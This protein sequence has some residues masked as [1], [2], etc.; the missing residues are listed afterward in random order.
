MKILRSITVNEMISQYL[1]NEFYSDCFNKSIVKQLKDLGLSQDIILNP[2]INDEVQNDFRGRILTGYRGFANKTF[3]FENFPSEVEWTRALINQDEIFRIQYIN[4]E[5]WIELA[6]GTRSP[7]EAS[8]NIRYELKSFNPKIV[9][10]AESLRMGNI[11]NTLILVTDHHKLI[12]LDGHLRITAYM[13]EPDL[14][15]HSLEVIVGFS[16]KLSNWI[17]Y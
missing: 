15:P 7:K 6:G 10:A 3:M 2:D 4:S 14:I 9:E 16:P 5:D 17:Y 11:F 12:I 8:L 13:L 1:L